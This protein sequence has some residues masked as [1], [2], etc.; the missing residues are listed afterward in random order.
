MS[1]HN[2]T[3]AAVSLLVLAFAAVGKKRG[4]GGL[5]VWGPEGKPI[6]S[7]D[8]AAGWITC[9]DPISTETAKPTSCSGAGQVT[10]C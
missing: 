6:W 2:R 5:V 9:G 7:R 3:I 10:W 1:V 8:I 4:M